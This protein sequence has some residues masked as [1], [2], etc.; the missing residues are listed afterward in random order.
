M[1]VLFP[2][3]TQSADI[4]R[5]EL[6]TAEGF[7]WEVV[8]IGEVA[9]FLT[10]MQLQSLIKAYAPDMVVVSGMC[11]ADFSSVETDTGIPVY[12]GT[13]HAADIRQCFH[14]I[15]SESLSKTVAADVLLE[16]QMQE[17]T[18]S[19]LLQRE[20]EASSSFIIRNVKFGGSSR[21]KVLS[22]IMDAHRCR[23]LREVAE[24]AIADGADGIDL[25][26]GFDAE[27][28]DVV[29]CFSALRDMPCVL[30]IDTLNPL[31]IE[32]SLFR[33]DMILS[34]TYE[35]LDVLADKIGDAVVV[36]IPYGTH[37][38]EETVN[39]AK[40]MGLKRL[41]V[42][43][44]LQ[45]PLSGMMHSVCG[46][47]KEYGVPKLM[48]CVNV[49]ELV[50]A[51]SPG[52]CALL[53]GMAVECGCSSVL[54]SEHSDKTQGAVR[55]MRRAADMMLAAVGRPYP[56]DV[57]CNGFVIKEKR[58]RREPALCYDEVTDAEIDSQE[59]LN[60]DP[61]GDFRIGVEEGFI[62]A[63][64]RNH[65]IRGRTADAVFAAIM[66]DGGVSL[67]NHAAYLGKELYKAELSLR[68]GRSF[69]QD[70]EF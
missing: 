47:M 14:L 15:V 6:A 62:V 53:M 27:P 21:V 46:F 1:F 25:G 4:L 40:S 55:E 17:K 32:V 22:E 23:N 45:P 51:D 31:L 33:A 56:K 58:K 13:W 49:T 12:R 67:L 42:D 18:L 52:M 30:S 65:A 50:D 24:K 59:P 29:R 44:L 57:G 36:L 60:R 3:G 61:C 20:I 69:E 37:T 41:L 68:F 63:V 48:G 66:A 39:K 16:T 9:S 2:T 38:L 8:S 5:R 7:S 10:K 64:R 54:I 43:P 35:T 70:G 19:L 11:T 26:F 28:D 34:L